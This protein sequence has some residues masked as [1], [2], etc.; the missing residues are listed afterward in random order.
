[1]PST[2]KQRYLLD[3]DDLIKEQFMTPVNSRVLLQGL[4]AANPGIMLDPSIGGTG[5]GSYTNQKLLYYDATAGR[6]MSSEHDISLLNNVREIVD[7]FHTGNFSATTPVDRNTLLAAAE[8]SVLHPTFV[9]PVNCQW[10]YFKAQWAFNIN[11]EIGGVTNIVVKMGTDSAPLSDLSSLYSGPFGGGSYWHTWSAE[12]VV[13][14][15]HRLESPLVIGIIV[16]GAG[17]NPGVRSG[18][19]HVDYKPVA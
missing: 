11:T 10:V 4:N 14:E 12:G 19:I 3:G 13:P 7:P 1:M 5:T 8:L 16:T 9:L 2:R 6:I 17:D 15:A 18:I